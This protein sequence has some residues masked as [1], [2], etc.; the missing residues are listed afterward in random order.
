MKT[1]AA[2]TSTPPSD[3]SNRAGSD[4]ATFL[5]AATTMSWQL[6][7]VVLVPLLGGAKLDDVFNTA[8]LLTIVG[9]GLAMVG[10]GAVVWRQLQLHSPP[11]T[12]ADIAHAKK[13]RDEEDEE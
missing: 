4:K 5:A 3:M 9:F 8:P 12:P 1:T 11:I 6:A 13:L 2:H 7:I 10:M